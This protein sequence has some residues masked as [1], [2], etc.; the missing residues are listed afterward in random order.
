MCLK[1]QKARDF[2]YLICERRRD[3]LWKP[4]LESTSSFL[5][6]AEIKTWEVS[7]LWFL[8]ESKQVHISPSSGGCQRITSLSGRVAARRSDSSCIRCST[9]NI[10]MPWNILEGYKV[11]GITTS[12]GTADA[13]I[14]CK[15]TADAAQLGS[16]VHFHVLCPHISFRAHPNEHLLPL[17]G[18]K[19]ASLIPCFSAN[20]PLSSLCGIHSDCS[21]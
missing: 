14:K 17:N 7:N 5:S 1:E 12:C 19:V 3:W 2:F 8:L 9:V 18:G 10:I 4:V 21:L 13:T 16:R 11:D 6:E 20:Q 15:F